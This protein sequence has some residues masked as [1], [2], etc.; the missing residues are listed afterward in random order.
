MIIVASLPSLFGVKIVSN[1]IAPTDPNMKLT[2]AL[3]WKPKLMGQFIFFADHLSNIRKAWFGRI[4]GRAYLRFVDILS[5]SVNDTNILLNQ[6][7]HKV[8]NQWLN[9]SWWSWIAT[10]VVLCHS[11]LCLLHSSR[12]D[13]YPRLLVLEFVPFFACSKPF[14]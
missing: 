10:W 6:V 11:L 1:M 2:F 12:F 14:C 8:K 7:C 4:C 3:G 9:D 13:Q 5:D